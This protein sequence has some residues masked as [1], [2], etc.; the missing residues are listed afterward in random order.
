MTLDECLADA[1]ESQAASC[2]STWHAETWQHAW[3]SMVVLMVAE[4][5]DDDWDG[6]DGDSS[7]EIY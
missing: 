6:A 1:L 7:S 3:D 5:D 4:G 2:P